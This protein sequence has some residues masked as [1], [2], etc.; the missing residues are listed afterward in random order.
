[1]SHVLV[2]CDTR[3]GIAH[4]HSLE[5]SKED[6]KDKKDEKATEE[7]KAIPEAKKEKKALCN[8]VQR[9][10]FSSA[11]DTIKWCRMFC[12]LNSLN[13]FKLSL[14]RFT[15]VYIIFEV[16]VMV[17]TVIQV[18]CCRT[19]Q[20]DLH[21]ALKKF[22]KNCWGTR[23]KWISKKDFVKHIKVSIDFRQIL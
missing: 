23:I 7:K 22:C 14:H 9:S 10:L 5:D 21:K 15:Y 11:V 6:S 13:M 4:R 3:F 16:R 2:W 12:S 1:M 17:P 18:Q 19:V 20:L 8:T